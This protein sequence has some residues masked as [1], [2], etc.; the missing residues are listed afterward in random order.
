MCTN[1]TERQVDGICGVA[2]GEFAGLA[3]IDQ[4]RTAVDALHRL[5]RADLLAPNAQ[6]RL[7]HA[8]HVAFFFARAGAGLQ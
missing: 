4:H 8:D 3:D 1:A 2:G 6:Q 5:A 7:E